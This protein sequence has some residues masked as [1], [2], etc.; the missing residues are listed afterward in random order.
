MDASSLFLHL[1]C[2]FYVF[3]SVCIE[4]YDCF[5]GLMGRKWLLSVRRM[6]RLGGTGKN[7]R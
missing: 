7:K 6:F 5:I 4:R 1:L 2:G 3:V